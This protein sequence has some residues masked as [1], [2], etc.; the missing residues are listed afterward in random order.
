MNDKYK[1]TKTHIVD[2]TGHIVKINAK[3]NHYTVF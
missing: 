3:V 1:I 2:D